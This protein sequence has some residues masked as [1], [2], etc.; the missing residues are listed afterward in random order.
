[1]CCERLYDSAGRRPKMP[2]KKAA[3]RAD[4][5]TREEMLSLDQA[6]EA[7]G[8]S[9]ST[10]Y[11]WQTQGRVRGFKVGRQW[12]YRRSDLD[13]FGQMTHPSAADVNVGELGTLVKQA[14]AQA[15]GIGSIT[16]EPPLPDYPS[17]EEEKAVERLFLSLLGNCAQGGASDIHID[18]ERD[19]SLVRQ[20]VDG[21]LHETLRLPK[22][23]HA[24]VIACIKAH[25]GM[26]LDQ[27]Q[28]PQDGRLRFRADGT[29][30]DVRVAT[31][32]AVHGES[33][34]M[35][36]LPQ[37]ATLVGLDR[38]GMSPSDL[39][40]YQRALRAP[41]GLMIVTGP[42]GSGKT[43]VLYAGLRSISRPDLKIHSVEDPVEY[44]FPHVTQVAVNR[45]AG[46]TFEAAQ[47]AL[48]RHDPDVIMVGEL[49][50]RESAELAAQAAITG[51]LVMTQL[52]AQ[53]APG[54]ITRLF[55]ME[56][57]PF[58][59]AH[60]LIYVSAQR[61]A[62]RVCPECAQPDKPD[63]DLLSPLAAQ[64]R[65]GGY[66]L[67]DEPTFMRGA[68]C[69]NCRQTGYRG[70][71]GLYET[72][73]VNQEIR[74]LIARRAGTAEIEAAAVRSGMTTLAADGLR[75]A[76]EGITSVAE[77]ARLLPGD[78]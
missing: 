33:A 44:A 58:V 69:G 31:I 71:T 70:R 14:E 36:I 34:V 22:S 19:A 4:A 42:T 74:G 5:P 77:V 60:T 11:R 76:A 64:A 27:R 53:T 13:K 1:M 52:H 56:L 55:E 73:E 62:R 3:R 66:R 65:A 30:Y 37:S 25:A 32:P 48:M 50:S 75:K 78:A 59:I 57:E 43:T 28:L 17:T 40:R 23:A 24:A 20:R 61:L 6:A 7:L 49:Q 54:A 41:C 2:R 68:G 35:R 16:V 51:H 12:R 63:F 45:K 72:L 15:K 29:E 8:V 47:R 38:V 67:P 21:V 18:P 39:E 10:L 46:L 26:L 9:R